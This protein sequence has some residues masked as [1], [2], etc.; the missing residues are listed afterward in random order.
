MNDPA[1]NIRVGTAGWNYR[2]WR[3]PFYPADLDSKQWFAY[4]AERFHTVEIN[5][6]LAGRQSPLEITADFVYI[7][8]HGPGDAYQGLYEEDALLGWAG[9]IRQWAR[10]GRQ[11]YRYFDNDENGYAARNALRLQELLRIP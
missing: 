11:V 8:L 3:G 7:R 2:H 9:A 5:F 6:D 1:S 10:G 4:Y